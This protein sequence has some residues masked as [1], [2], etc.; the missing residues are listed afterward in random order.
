[1][2]G[3]DLTGSQNVRQWAPECNVFS[4]RLN[5]SKV[6]SSLFRWFGRLFHSFGVVVAKHLSP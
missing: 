2:Y 5:C 1:V 6:N 3:V 4:S